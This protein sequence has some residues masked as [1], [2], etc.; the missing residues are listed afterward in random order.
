MQDTIEGREGPPDQEK[1]RAR[2]SSRCWLTVTQSGEE[3]ER[4]MG[5]EPALVAWESYAGHYAQFLATQDSMHYNN[6]ALF[7]YRR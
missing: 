6:L 7:R 4:V 5:I 3:V 1:S 2:S